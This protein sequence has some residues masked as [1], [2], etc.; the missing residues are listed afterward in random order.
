MKN[1][2]L[3]NSGLTDQLMPSSK[4][5]SKLDKAAGLIFSLLDFAL[6]WDMFCQLQQPHNKHHGAT[7]VTV[8]L[9]SS[10]FAN[11]TKWLK[12]LCEALQIMITSMCQKTWKII[13]QSKELWNGNTYFRSTWL[14]L[15]Q[16]FHLRS[17]NLLL[18]RAFCFRSV[19]LQALYL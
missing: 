8:L 4:N 5:N 19:V 12:W 6:S 14:I 16:A 11:N 3:P 9:Y 15:P 13:E 2:K 18:P 7:I 10:S 1:M 17:T